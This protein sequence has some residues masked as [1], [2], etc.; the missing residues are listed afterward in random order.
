MYAELYEFAWPLTILLIAVLAI[1]RLRQI[2]HGWLEVRDRQRDRSSSDPWLDMNV[3]VNTVKAVAKVVAATVAIRYEKKQGRPNERV[4]DEMIRTLTMRVS[5]PAAREAL[6]RLNILW[7]HQDDDHDIF[8]K[9]AFQALGANVD[10]AKST[11]EALNTLRQTKT[12]NFM[13]SNLNRPGD[14]RQDGKRP[15]EGYAGFGL[16]TEVRATTGYQ[17]LPF[18]IYSRSIN[19]DIRAH[20]ARLGI[21]ILTNDPSVLFEYVLD[22][23]P[24]R[25]QAIRPTDAE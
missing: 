24:P 21:Q 1:E 3:N 8:E 15:N 23:G 9:Q 19:D 12:V 16:Y 7:V 6:T 22:H 25:R 10:F 5:R 4:I 18:I 2:G 11:D 13:I 20:A 17:N 14:Q